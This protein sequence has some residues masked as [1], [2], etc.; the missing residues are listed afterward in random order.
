MT[1]EINWIEITND[2]LKILEN[3]LELYDISFPIDV[4][5]PHGVFQKGLKYATNNFPNSFRFLVGM[6]GNTVVSFATGHYLADVNI[7]FIVYI[8][9]NPFARRKGIGSQTLSKIEEL[10]NQDA[11]SA[12]NS[13]LRL[14]ILETEIAEIVP[15]KE[16]KED[17][18][19]RQRF[20]EKN[21]YGKCEGVDYLQPPL[22]GGIEGIPLFLFIKN[23]Q[24]NQVVTESEI[25]AIIRAMY[26]EKYYAVNG[27]DKAVLT[28]CLNK[29][30]VANIIL[31]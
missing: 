19:K 5:E 29:M 11:I 12:G 3:V 8:A 2:N 22:N 6:E 24:G 31:E 26:R 9:T 25:S 14:S 18:V 28:H 4:R 7:G 13:S 10:L 20:F 30:K 17:C 21:N 27:I 15:T 16:E 23:F 1:A